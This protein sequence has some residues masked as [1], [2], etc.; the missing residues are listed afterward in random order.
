MV[1]VDE[2]RDGEVTHTP[3][4]TTGAHR[5]VGQEHEGGADHHG[6]VHLGIA[7]MHG[8]GEFG[9]RDHT[10]F[11]TLHRH[12]AGEVGHGR[13]ADIDFVEHVVEHVLP[14][15]EEVIDL[16][17]DGGGI[18][19]H[20]F[21]LE[22]GDDGIHVVVCHRLCQQ[23]A[24]GC[25][26]RDTLLTHLDKFRLLVPLEAHHLVLVVHTLVGG[27]LVEFRRH[28]LQLVRHEEGLAHQ[29]DGQ[30]EI[31]GVAFLDDVHHA[32]H[33]HGVAPRQRLVARRWRCHLSLVLLG[34]LT[35][36]HRACR[37]IGNACQHDHHQHESEY[38]SQRHI[39]VFHWIH[40]LYWA[41]VQRMFHSAKK[42]THYLNKSGKPL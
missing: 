17:D 21:D 29:R 2:G 42:I 26:R 38:S 33:L 40:V 28:L 18:C 14:A 41:K 9:E 37:G 32:L 27:R 36:E 24:F 34:F 7:F 25:L 6:D 8:G 4:L 12:D 30:F 16:E 22:R 39:F 13:G 31:D 23:G 35:S 5:L 11:I 19:R 20:G 1:V 15:I 3:V 10:A